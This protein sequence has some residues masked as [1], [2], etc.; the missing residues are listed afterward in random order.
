MMDESRAYAPYPYPTGLPAAAGASPTQLDAS[1]S[2]TQS[3]SPGADFDL[4]KRAYEGNTG[5]TG[6][7]KKPRFNAYGPGNSRGAN[8]NQG[9]GQ[10]GYDLYGRMELNEVL[11]NGMNTMGGGF[12]QGSGFVNN[13]GSYGSFH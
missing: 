6:M 10:G 13:M 7:D 12:G 8:G 2:N 9:N 1:P 5:G 11:A 4:M 3:N